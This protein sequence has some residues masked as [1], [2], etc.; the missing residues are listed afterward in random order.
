MSNRPLLVPGLVSAAMLAG[1]LGSWPY[2]YYT[3]LRWVVCAAAIVFAVYGFNNRAQWATW[4]FGFVALLFNP[5][6]P[7]TLTRPIWAPIDLA[8]AAVFAVG[9]VALTT[10]A[11][12]EAGPA[13]E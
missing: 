2:G 12:A 3:L 5:I 7:V 10:T 8:V 4:V 13:Q 9:A 6:V 1:A 11:S